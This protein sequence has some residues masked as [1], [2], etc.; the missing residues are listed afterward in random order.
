MTYIEQMIKDMC[1]HGVE[2]KTL[3][4]VCEMKRGSTITANQA[5]EGEIPLVQCIIK[6]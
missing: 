4:E 6:E 1:P 3:G 2:W 5:E